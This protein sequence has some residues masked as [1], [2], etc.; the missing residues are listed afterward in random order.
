MPLLRMHRNC[1]L[2]P[3]HSTPAAAISSCSISRASSPTH[4]AH[5]HVELGALADGPKLAAQDGGE[6]QV[7][8][9]RTV[10]VYGLEGKRKGQG[11]CVNHRGRLNIC[12]AS[13]Y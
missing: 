5:L 3:N 7:Q 2:E 12:P 8:G 13:F 9:L 4:S 11:S 10:P 6:A 1:N